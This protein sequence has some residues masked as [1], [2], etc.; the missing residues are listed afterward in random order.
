MDEDVL[1]FFE[2]NIKRYLLLF[3]L[4]YLKFVFS[5]INTDKKTA[6]QAE[7][8][9]TLVQ[10]VANKSQ[11]KTAPNKSPAKE[12]EKSP[13]KEEKSRNTIRESEVDLRASTKSTVSTNHETPPKQNESIDYAPVPNIWWLYL[14]VYRWIKSQGEPSSMLEDPS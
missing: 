4:E 1:R 5:L 7:R 2:E 9:L 12:E 3:K 14:N 10:D 13:N 8:N 11:A 6:L